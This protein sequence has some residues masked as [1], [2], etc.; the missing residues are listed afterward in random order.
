MS[1]H[2]DTVQNI[3]RDNANAR[4][5]R[6]EDRFGQWSEEANQITL[7]TNEAEE[8]LLD[9]YFAE[10]VTRQFGIPDGTH[11]YTFGGTNDTSTGDRKRRIA[12]IIF[13][14]VSPQLEQN[15]QHT[16]IELITAAL[17]NDSYSNSN[18]DTVTFE[19]FKTEEKISYQKISSGT[20]GGEAYIVVKG[21]ALKDKEATIEIFEKEPFLLMESETPLTVI[22]YDS[23][24]AEEP[25]ESVNK[26]QL[27]ATFNDGGE[28]VV[29]IKFR[30]KVEDPDDVFND[31]KEKFKPIVET[32]TNETGAVETSI[33]P[34]P[35]PDD[36]DT[37]VAPTIHKPPK[38]I[39]LLW[40]KV[41]AN[42]D[43]QEY[44]E[45]F[46]KIG[47]GYFQLGNN[48]C[49]Q[50]MTKEQL[51]NIAVHA[52]ESNVETH[53]SG[54]NEAFKDNDINTCLRRLHFLAQV[55][56]ES[57]SFRYTEELGVG[58]DAYGGFKGRGL[59][60]LTFR[61][62]YQAYGNF[63]GEDFTSSQENKEKLE[64][65]PHAARSAGWFWAQNAEL[66]DNADDNDLIYITYR[67]NGGFNGYNDRLEYVNR[68]FEV[69]LNSC[70]NSNSETTDYT[71]S[72]SKTYN[73]QKGSFGWGAWHDPG[74]NKRGC[75]KNRAKAI[76]GYERFISLNNAAGRTTP[77]RNWYGYN[78]N[79]IRSFVESRL[80]S[81]KN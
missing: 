61:S 68:G 56:H 40:L 1:G 75:T 76:E 15:G 71:F 7:A 18:G 36:L 81:L 31:W 72:E 5:Q 74:T 47:N 42:G 52:R 2:N 35:R 11:T 25:N 80:N 45:E 32:S 17:V 49:S 28:A 22:Q 29:K 79:S 62:N 66:N 34:Q 24:D 43:K 65:N 59:M 37:S 64:V 58:E 12:Q 10:Q 33:R 16:A 57:G 13:D 78:K 23:L 46:L 4:L 8:G 70:G 38:T 27:K 53:L 9:A 48:C 63:V 39:D 69:L 60:Q 21:F 6:I 67:I 30:P 51:M 41:K 77:S 44:E 54:I 50:D 26:T 73:E 55:I 3:A 14:R 19:I 20:L